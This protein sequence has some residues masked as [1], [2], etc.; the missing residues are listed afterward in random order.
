MKYAFIAMQR[1]HFPIALMCRLLGVSR[2]GFY[3]AH[4]RQPSARTLAD[5]RLRVHIRAVHRQS[6]STYGSPRV[7]AEL[8]AQG[9]RCGR[10]RIERLMRIEG[11]AA[12]PHRRQ[13]HTTNST[14]A[15]P[16]VANVLARQF[17]VTDVVGLN[18]VWVGDITYVPTREGW[19]YL[20]VLLDLASRSVVGWAMQPTLD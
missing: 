20:A 11:L 1:Q 13:R 7:H 6:R 15:H 17:A 10:K 18:R 2:S 12:K 4:K 9:V 3:A 19:L 8:R 5:Q 16:V 14:H